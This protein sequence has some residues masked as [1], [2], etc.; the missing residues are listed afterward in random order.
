MQPYKVSLMSPHGNVPGLTLRGAPPFAADYSGFTK[1]GGG[2]KARERKK[3]KGRRK[4][5][6]NQYVLRGEQRK[7]TVESISL[8]CPWP[9]FGCD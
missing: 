7:P 6:G 8:V 9:V 2:E 5:E 3:R 1:F 4:R